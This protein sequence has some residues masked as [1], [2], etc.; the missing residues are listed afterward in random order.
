VAIDPSLDT[1]ALGVAAGSLVLSLAVFGLEPALQLTRSLDLRGSLAEGGTG[2]RR[3]TRQRRLLRWQVA[4]STGFFVVATMFVKYTIA[5][6]RHDSGVEIDRLGVAVLS[7]PPSTWNEARVRQMLDRVVAA[8]QADPAVE[9][10]SVSTGMPFGL[11]TLRIDLTLPGSQTRGDV[12]ET[13]AIAATPS[14]FKTIG[15]PILRGRGFDDRDGSGAPPVVVVSEHTARLIFGSAD[16]VG[17]L[18]VLGEPPRRQSTAT[19]IGIARDTDVRSMFRDPAPLVYLPLAQRFDPSLTIAVRSTG[20]VTRAVGALQESI[21]RIDP[22]LALD[23]IGTGRTILAGPSVLL[24]ALGLSA[25][26]LGGLT[27]L[28]AMAGLFGIQSHAVASRT[29]EIGVR[30]SF[31]ASP[32]EIHWMV[33]KDGTLPVLDGLAL[34]VCAGLAGRAIARAYL[35]L[36]ISILDPWI[37]VVVP[38]PVVLAGFCACYL[39]AARAARVDPNVALRHL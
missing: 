9:T 36:D 28:L 20:D 5:E 35:D 4:I 15:V 37:L 14:L 33:L 38:I 24:R 22:D 2:P 17:R 3:T 8:L 13:A 12:H 39:P 26:A 31:G 23:G 30:M 1:A 16:A 18:V 32:A 34:G 21:R 10:T 29:R 6:A 19:V 25:L 27:L 11:R 7:D